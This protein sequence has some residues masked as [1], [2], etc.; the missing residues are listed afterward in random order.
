M[1]K[2]LIISDNQTVL[3]ATK[4]LVLG[5]YDVLTT[6]NALT[7]FTLLRDFK[8]IS[9]V[10]SDTRAGDISGAEFLTEAAKID[11]TAALVMMV[12]PDRAE[13]QQG[14]AGRPA[15][16]H[17]I[18]KPFDAGQLLTLLERLVGRSAPL[19]PNGN[20][21]HTGAK[22]IET[23]LSKTDPDLEFSMVYQPRICAK[24]A[25]TRSVGAL[26]RWN[27]PGLGAVAPANFIPVAE[28]TGDILWI[29]DWTLQNACNTARFWMNEGCDPIP[30]SV[31]VSSKVCADTRLIALA[32]NAIRVSGIT[33][34]LLRLEI[35]DGLNLCGN[36]KACANTATLRELG[37]GVTINGTLDG[38]IDRGR[39]H[40]SCISDH[41]DC[42][43]GGQ[44]LIGRIAGSSG[45]SIL[46]AIRDL[47]RNLGIKTVAAG[48][49]NLQHA[50]LIR[51][52]GFDQM[53]GFHISAPL[54]KADLPG[55][56]KSHAPA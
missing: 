32:A 46:Q 9:A 30:V 27:N 1:Q 51:K 26:L 48:V 53:Q 40:A 4:K 42:L 43:R 6:D 37:V 24:A 55:W 56:V 52:L 3:A 12:D 33:P 15:V 7:A 14:K 16:W 22:T 19:P 13:N 38:S 11:S 18:E 29:T 17:S 31:I 39:D 20:G 25:R 21:R 2:V 5:R 45:A 47:G 36:P 44:E 8:K 23:A 41:T 35:A 50:R 10:V 49:E 54:P 34:D 28:K